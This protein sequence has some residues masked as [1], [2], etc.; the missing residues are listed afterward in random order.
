MDALL[1]YS[2][3]LGIGKGDLSKAKIRLKVAQLSVDYA[4]ALAKA[5][6]SAYQAEKIHSMR[7]NPKDAWDSVCVLSEGDTIHNSSPTVMQM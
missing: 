6:W 5:A 3:T 7:F 4:I 1:Y 2:R